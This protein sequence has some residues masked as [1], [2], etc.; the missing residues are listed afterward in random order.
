MKVGTKE[1]SVTVLALVVIGLL[2]IMIWRTYSEVTVAN[3]QRQQASEIA[4]GMSQL[5]L[6][7]F[8]YRLYHHDRAKE[9]WFAISEHVDKL[10]AQAEYSVPAQAR[11]L[12]AIKERRANIWSIFQELVATQ[13][14]SVADTPL[15]QPTR[16]FEGQLLTRML[17]EQQDNFGDAFRLTDIASERIEAAQRKETIL[18]LMGLVLI[19]MIK[20][21]ASWLIN[22]QVLG[23]VVR[24]Q[25][26][27]R[28]VATGNWNVRLD[29]RGND[30]IGD[31]S[32]NFEAM[33]RSLRNSFEE[34]G[35]ANRELAT[36]NAEL[37]A[38]SYS[39]SHD[40]R[41]PLRSLD[42]FSQALLEDYDDKLDHQGKDFLHRI[43]SASQRMGRLI[44]DLL[45]LSRVTRTELRLNE[46]SLGDIAKEISQSLAQQEGRGEVRWEI[47][48]GMRVRAD[49]DLM[50]IALHNLLENAWKYSGGST[51]P[52]I[53][54]GTQT[55][56]S[57]TVFFVADNGA[58]FD[59]AHAGKL[60]GAFQRLH[61]AAE[62]PGTGIGLAIVQR[63][64]RRHGG[65][66]WA[67]ARPG[68]GATF[69]FTLSEIAETTHG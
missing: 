50:R 64:I 35:A 49:G 32:K 37:E 66:I 3:R 58:G 1:K 68:E 43:R 46:V 16:L 56:A 57:Q 12:A 54:F 63:V 69:F 62:F 42:G 41:S 31:L 65:T 40:L 38:F 60:F 29:A 17:A 19:G 53:R 10:V 52:L 15:D 23:P 14:G 6:L 21:G 22:R 36:V 55:K 24:L 4:R 2:A 27:T 26:A 11:I 5:H 30:E 44:D 25:Q 20:L 39:V 13:A 51:A 9:Q 7:T 48:P 8:E 45:R 18:I 67:E 59:M 61:S 47:E 33:T 34:I 28:E